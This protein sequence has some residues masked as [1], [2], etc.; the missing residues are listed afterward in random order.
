MTSSAQ[1]HAAG[2]SEYAR[3]GA[4]QARLLGNRGPLRLDANG[5]LHPDILEAYWEHVFYVFEGLVEAA[6]VNELRAD[7]DYLLDHAPTGQGSN[8]DP[9]CR[10]LSGA[11]V[12]PPGWKNHLR[13]QAPIQRRHDSHPVHA[14]RLPR[15]ACGFSTETE[16]QSNSLSRRLCTQLAVA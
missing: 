16:S 1:A 14:K 6:E 11:A 7:I 13:T 2:M 3:A 8:L 4:E 10:D 15:K 9:L 5:Q 12:D